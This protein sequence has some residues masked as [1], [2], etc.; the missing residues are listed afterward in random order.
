MNL[1]SGDI[2]TLD[3]GEK[4]KVTLEVIEE[5]VTELEQGKRYL[6]RYTGQFYSMSSSTIDWE[7]KNVVVFVGTV[8]GCKNI[9]YS[10]RGKYYMFSA[11]DLDYI[12]KKIN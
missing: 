12:V 6:L 5:K 2:I 1:K 9:F 4:V 7:K 10:P 8:D 3:N 11:D